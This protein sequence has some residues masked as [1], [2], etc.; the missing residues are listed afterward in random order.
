MV[1]AQSQGFDSLWNDQGLLIS[2]G[3][4]RIRTIPEHAVERI[5]SRILIT[6]IH[7]D[8]LKGWKLFQKSRRHRGGDVDGG[9]LGKLGSLIIVYKDIVRMILYAVVGNRRLDGHRCQRGVYQFGSAKLI[10]IT[11]EIAISDTANGDRRFIG[12]HG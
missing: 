9:E 12:G 5:A 11:P 2:P 7:M 8:S 6:A 4:G 1:F 3:D 10:G